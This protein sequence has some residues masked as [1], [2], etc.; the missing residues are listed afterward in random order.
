MEAHTPTPSQIREPM[1]LYCH[2]HSLRGGWR[3]RHRCRS[4]VW[5]SSNCITHWQ[6]PTHLQKKLHEFLWF[7]LRHNLSHDRNLCSRKQIPTSWTCCTLHT[8]LK[9]TCKA[10]LCQANLEE[11]TV[12]FLEQATLICCWPDQISPIDDEMMMNSISSCDS[13]MCCFDESGSTRI[14]RD[15]VLLPWAG[16]SIGKWNLPKYWIHGRCYRVSIFFHTNWFAS[17]GW[18]PPHAQ[19]ESGG[20]SQTY[21]QKMCEQAMK[22]CIKTTCRTITINMHF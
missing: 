1:K 22:T 13:F 5:K 2:N 8:L 18:L 21:A 17:P 12:F 20:L 15:H 4:W 6:K 7:P 3:D 19:S 16:W 9:D 14:C 10:W 11:S